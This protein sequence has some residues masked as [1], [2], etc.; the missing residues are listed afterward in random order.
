MRGAARH[1]TSPVSRCLTFV[2]AGL[3]EL[4][5]SAAEPGARAMATTG[6]GEA[7]DAAAWCEVLRD[8]G[9]RLGL[10]ELLA[11]TGP[12]RFRPMGTTRRS[13]GFTDDVFWL[14]WRLRNDGTNRVQPVM[15]LGSTRFAELDWHV[16]R[17]TNAVLVERM[18]MMR[19]GVARRLDTR[20][21]AFG[22]ELD[23][24]E[25]VDVYLRAWT[26]A[27][28]YFLPTLHPSL[29]VHGGARLRAEAWTLAG[30]GLMASV[31]VLGTVFGVL[32]R[33]RLYG[34]S[35]GLVLV[36]GVFCFIHAGYWTWLGWPWATDMVWLPLTAMN[37]V[38]S[39]MA[40][41]FTR[42]FLGRDAI[43]RTSDR[44]LTGTMWGT[45]AMAA[46]MLVLPYRG[47][48]PG[49]VEHGPAG[50]LAWLRSSTS[51]AGGVNTVNV[52]VFLVCA[53]V[54]T[55]QWLTQRKGLALWLA[56]MWTAAFVL[57]LALGLQWQGVMPFV[58]AP[59]SALLCLFAMMPVLF[60]VLS[61][62]RILGLAKERRRAQQM[63]HALVESRFSALRY[64]MNPHFLFNSLNSANGLVLE[65]AS[66]APGFLLLLARYLRSS[67]DGAPDGRVSLGR[68]L[69]M[70]AD[71]LAIEKVRF[72]ESLQVELNV[73][74][75]LNSCEVP[76]LL[77]QPLLENAIR[78]GSR[79]ASNVL[80]VRVVASLHES[81][82][83]LV[84]ANTGR[85]QP[86]VTLPDDGPRRCDGGV[87]LSNLRE[88]LG[89][90]FGSRCTMEV[91]EERGWVFVRLVLPFRVAAP[92]KP[93]TK[94]AS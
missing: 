32:G 29:E 22:V 30:A 38:C 91:S 57:R 46:G 19:A 40:T 62:A 59:A 72:E 45:L 14:R 90:L 89:L 86:E 6:T 74:E 77:L 47:G 66:R 48:V 55:V 83:C 84:V 54:A 80:R 39:F 53:L 75:A 23:P 69:A 68:E 24:G 76:E 10:A 34:I 9:G 70:A 93:F 71:Y 67:L 44:I 52:T 73:P 11:G 20:L 60:L 63:E 61:A 18:G 58:L 8:P 42:E 82:L 88:R 25:E 87:G 92:G 79:D 56:L 16:V 33:E 13:F 94:A 28:V 43:G 5:L 4:G 31:M 37:H 81:R 85:L 27:S 51:V 3:I 21:P 41:W 36:H 49:L 35:A 2:I 17:G 65:D 78:H 26:Q 50:F 1:G 64:Q 15:E 7:V 12:G